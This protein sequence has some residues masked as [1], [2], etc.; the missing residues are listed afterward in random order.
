MRALSALPRFAYGASLA[1]F[2]LLFSTKAA[3]DILFLNLQGSAKEYNEVVQAAKKRGEKVVEIPTFSDADRGTISK[4][5]AKDKTARTSAEHTTLEKLA[6][7][8]RLSESGAT[9]AGAPNDITKFSIKIS[10]LLPMVIEETL[11]NTPHGALHSLVISGHSTGKAYL[12]DLYSGKTKIE[13]I[14]GALSRAGADKNIQSI[15][16]LGCYG[17]TPLTVKKWHKGLPELKVVAGFS[18]KAPLAKDPDSSAM[19]RWFY[20]KVSEAEDLKMLEVAEKKLPQA[21]KQR[22]A[23]ASLVCASPDQAELDRQCPDIIKTLKAS[24][25]CE[26]F[27][28]YYQSL[29]K[30]CR[31]VPKDRPQSRLRGFYAQLQDAEVCL[32]G[33]KDCARD[34]LPTIETTLALVKFQHVLENFIAK[35]KEQIGQASRTRPTLP[36]II[37]SGDREQIRS[38]VQGMK[39]D[40]GPIPGKFLEF[41]DQACFDFAS[42]M[43]NLIELKCIPI[44][45]IESPT[46]GRPVDNLACENE[47]G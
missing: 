21:L 47:C 30:T 19:I 26:N 33:R 40:C 24:S 17:R 20:D 38:L 45:W 46:P 25:D 1:T 34:G 35:F 29:E 9:P 37:Q 42:A 44:S 43:D 13:E 2:L 39:K 15:L 10:S 32:D 14:H 16:L 4:I 22:M 31:K 8:Y 5:I 41:K 28:C 36:R 23:G 27:R 6:V 11:K 18:R 3:A 12:S 7:K